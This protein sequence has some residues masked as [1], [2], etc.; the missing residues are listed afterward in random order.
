MRLLKVSL[1]FIAQNIRSKFFEAFIHVFG[2]IFGFPYWLLDATLLDNINE[3][4]LGAGGE[5][6]EITFFAILLAQIIIVS[7]VSQFHIV[8]LG[9][10]IILVQLEDDVACERRYLC[11]IPSHCLVSPLLRDAL[12][13][14]EIEEV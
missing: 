13:A 10:T 7:V 2:V 9:S 5:L 11:A 1:S 4:G 8:L 3:L 14:G 12:W 6:L